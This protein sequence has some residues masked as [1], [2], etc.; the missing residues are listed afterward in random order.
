MNSVFS[1]L[2]ISTISLSVPFLLAVIGGYL[3]ERSGVIN[4]ALEGCLLMGAAAGSLV[5]NASH[6]SAIGVAGAVAMA[7]ALCWVHF[8]VTQFFQVD[9][10]ISGIAINVFALGAS[11]FL[12]KRFP[13]SAS[14]ADMPRTWHV[15]VHIG[16]STLPI[17]VLTIAAY[18]APF[19]AAIYVRKSR[20]GLR[21]IAIG[22]D[23]E[24]SKLNG[25]N[26]LQVRFFALTFTGILT[27]LAGFSLVDASGRFT[28]NISAGKGYIALS[29]LIL[30]NWRP[31]PSLIACVA[32]GFLQATQISLQGVA[33]FGV[34]IPDQV[35]QSLPYL[36]A[37]IALAGLLGK[38]RPPFGLGKT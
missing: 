22:N 36:A 12:D 11:D 16:Q 8:A 27:G 31:I 2:L 18:L 10:V 32:F 24:K 26:P 25:V 30:S 6:S 35:W 33:P 20:F 3:S 23:S 28:D 37:I 1:V 19:L 4:I 29:A 21:L 15:A 9:Q 5:A 34:H 38:S 7:I 14:Y 17:S 13:Y